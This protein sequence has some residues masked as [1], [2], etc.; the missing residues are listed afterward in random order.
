MSECEMKGLSLLN[1]LRVFESLFGPSRGAE[2]LARL[3]DA[4]RGKLSDG[5][6]VA[7]GWYPVSLKC[8]LHQAAFELTGDMGLARKMGY[9]MTKR[10]LSGIY[11][12]LVR[13][14]VCPE[15][16]LPISARILGRYLRPV[17]LAI[18]EIKPQSVR[19]VFS[20]GAG[21]TRELWEDLVGG[22]LASLEVAG[23]RNVH[24]RIEAG[25]Q[26]GDQHAR[27]LARWNEGATL[28][29]T[30]KPS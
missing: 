27:C 20:E 25:G 14:V 26:A 2:L 1:Y 6:I 28:E 9:E 22:C 15:D 5:E 21:F 17:K 3:P 30:S 11:A 16:V 7:N 24:V 29:M 23:A 12:M 18:E 13:V 10:D 8:A 19:F 4:L